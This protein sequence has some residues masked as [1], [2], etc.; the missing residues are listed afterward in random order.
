MKRFYTRIFMNYEFFYF[1]TSYNYNIFWRGD[2]YLIQRRAISLFKVSYYLKCSCF[3][4]SSTFGTL[5]LVN[6]HVHMHGER[7]QN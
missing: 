4:H 6:L 2:L 3:A 7:N 1:N 5:I